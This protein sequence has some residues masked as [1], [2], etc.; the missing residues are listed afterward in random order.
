MDKEK[1]ESL[2]IDYIDGALTN[3]DRETVE[4]EIARNENTA[5][6]YREL[7]EVMGLMDNA[8]TTAPGASLR[9]NFEQVL[10]SEIAQS[11]N[12]QKGKQIFMQPWVLR[13]AAAVVL[14]IVVAV[15]ADRVIENRK[16][17]RELAGI[18]KELEDN[19]KLMMAMLED[20]QSASQRLMGTTVA[21]ETMKHVDDEIVTALVK[22]MQSDPNTNVRLSALEA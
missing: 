5:R 3:E 6:L 8:K 2:L 14:I 11:G 16:H 15:A 17:E 1:L 19:K 22:A 10:Q 13:V 9:H 12:A 4:S 18:R 21:Y 20:R 7:K